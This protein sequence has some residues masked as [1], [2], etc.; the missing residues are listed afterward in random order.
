MIRPLVA[1]AVL[2]G[3]GLPALAQETAPAAPAPAEIVVDPTAS[4]AASRQ[5]NMLTGF[6]A[7]MAVIELCALT[8]DQPVLD[9]MAA[10]RTRLENALAME[11]PTGATAYAR[12]K[13][14]VEKTTPDCTE[15]SADRVSVDAVT[16]IYEAQTA[17]PAAAPAAPAEPAMAPAAPVAQ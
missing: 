11:A 15:G 9:G 3:L 6:Y 17:P 1:L 14:D 5:T 10:D 7:T 13:A 8:I 12:I 2:A 4:P 16:A